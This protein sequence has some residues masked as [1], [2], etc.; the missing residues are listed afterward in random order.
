MVVPDCNSAVGVPWTT[1]PTLGGSGCTAQVNNNSAQ[2][3]LCSAS[4]VY[5]IEG[6]APEGVEIGDV[7]NY[8][9]AQAG[10]DMQVVSWT[11]DEVEYYNGVTIPQ[12]VV[13][14][15]FKM[16]RA[17]ETSRFSSIGD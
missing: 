15:A 1:G 4:R 14:A 11:G 17:S 8:F 3:T 9:N 5:H 10:N 13:A 12:S 7:A 16:P 2:L 6:Q